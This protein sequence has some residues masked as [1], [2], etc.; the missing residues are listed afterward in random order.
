MQT[1]QEK[2]NRDN[3]KPLTLEELRVR[4]GKPIYVVYINDTEGEW[5]I[6]KSITDEY[7]DRYIRLNDYTG[8]PLSTV[9]NGTNKCYDYEAQ[10][11]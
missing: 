3:P 7:A 2:V 4:I 11:I 1:L 9:I 10:R 5:Y 8:I 6:L